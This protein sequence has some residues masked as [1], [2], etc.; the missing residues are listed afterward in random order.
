MWLLDL[1]FLGAAALPGTGAPVHG[2]YGAGPSSVPG[3]RLRR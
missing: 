2:C 1:G 3:D